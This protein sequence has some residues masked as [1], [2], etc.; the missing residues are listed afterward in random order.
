[1]SEMTVRTDHKW[2]HFLYSNEL[3]K[4]E[5]EYFHWMKKCDF[6]SGIF[7]RY[8]KQIYN[9]SE[10]MRIDRGCTAFPGEWQG[11]CADSY[12]SGTLIEV[13]KC[14]ESYKI[15]SYW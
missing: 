7:L 13:S 12:F 2:K 4:K 1:M 5:K 11:Y 8:K 14:G 10:F 15:A 3:T 9:L 6:E